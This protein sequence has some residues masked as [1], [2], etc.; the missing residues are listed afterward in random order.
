MTMRGSVQPDPLAVVLP[1][2]KEYVEGREEFATKIM[3]TEGS[4]LVR[5]MHAFIQ[6]CYKTPAV[7]FEEPTFVGFQ[8][9]IKDTKGNVMYQ[10]E[11]GIIL[12]KFVGTAFRLALKD[13]L[14]S[15]ADIFAERWSTDS[16]G[17]DTSDGESNE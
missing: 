12:A 14:P 10:A 5:V 4:I 7:P 2:P 17:S 1:V 13:P 16:R 15:E 8:D 9:S 11:E 6:E 3:E